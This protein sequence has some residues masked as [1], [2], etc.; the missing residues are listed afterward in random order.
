[1]GKQF[2]LTTADK[3]S[4]GAYR[5]DP[6]GKP[7]GG[8]VVIQEIFGV[9]HHIRSVCDRL[10][11]LGYVA[12]APAVFDRFVRDFEC[13]YTPDEIAHA[14]SYLGNLN[15]DH[16]IHD[17]AAAAGDLKKDVGPKGVIGFCMGGTAAFL[18]ACRIPGLSAAVAYY[19]GMIGKFADEKPKCPMQMH[20]G[21]KDEGIP[22]STVEEIKK[23]Q[24]QAEIYVYPAAA[25][26]F[27]CDERAS[28]NKD[29]AALAW[30]R[31]Q[32]FLA[33]NMK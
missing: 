26:G 2:T 32:E 4:L 21:E 22:M 16:M 29:A 3:H 1:L 20:F 11:A 30:K 6:Q 27:Y 15:W 10:A 31:T 23:K 12:V 19:G 25:H 14:R 8:L 13:G 9:N 24:P 7:K 28:Y 17:M 33:K 18:A 5:A